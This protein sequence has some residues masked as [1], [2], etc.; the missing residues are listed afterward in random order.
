VAARHVFRFVRGRDRV[1]DWLEGK[2][3]DLL[4]P[5]LA[6][7]ARRYTSLPAP[8]SQKYFRLLENRGVHITPVHFY[9]P[10]P[11]TRA[12]PDRLWEQPS[13]MVGIELNDAA[14]LALLQDVF[15]RF[16][17][18]YDRFAAAPTDVPHEFHFNNG[19]F[20]GTDALVLYCV[21]RHFRPR[22]IIE[23]GSGFSSRVSARAALANGDTRLLCIE[24]HPGPLFEQGFP[25]MT[26]LLRQ[27][28]QDVDPTVF[29]QLDANDILF[30]DS[31]HVVT[32]GSDVNYL[33]LE[34][35][36]RLRP[37]V[38]V[39]VHDVFL[40]MEMPKYLLTDFGLFWNEQ[41]LLQAFLTYN[42]EF[43]VL[44]ANAYMGM[45]YPAEMRAA[46]PFSQPFWGGGSFWLRRKERP[47]SGTFEP[48]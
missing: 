6:A 18:E 36:P 43:E 28:V 44:F 37:G 9:Q 33:F 7:L 34:V 17:T 21:V 32:C 4:A 38:L 2:I 22:L 46:F 45:R 10:I 12:L 30:M 40:P 8:L 39:H 35:L 27:P 11:D 48:V 16:R 13:A 15:P 47:Q 23:V 3:L 25:G 20:S 5:A 1:V 41:Y 26:K 24:P 19:M 29:E 14:Q 42:S 31:S